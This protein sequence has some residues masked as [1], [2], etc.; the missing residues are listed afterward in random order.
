[1]RARTQTE[2]QDYSDRRRVILYG[3]LVG[4]GAILTGLLLAFGGPVA[5]A[6]AIVAFFAAVIVLRNI[7]VGFWGV[8]AVVCLLPFATIPVDIGN[9][10]PA[11]KRRM[12]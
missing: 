9:G 6:A 7:E 5:A 3:A 1:M 12:V 4:S 11:T 2:N 8:I 10:R